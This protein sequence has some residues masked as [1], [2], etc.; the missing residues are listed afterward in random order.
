MDACRGAYPV[1]MMARLLAV[2]SSGY[3]EWRGRPL[4]LRAVAGRRLVEEMRTIHEER[5]GT[6]GSPR[7]RSELQARGHTE[8]RHRVARLMRAAHLR[9]SIKKR[10]RASSGRRAVGAV[11]RNVLNRD[12]IP[13]AP[14]Q[15][16]AGDITYVRTDEGWIYL[17]VVLDLYS[18]RVVGWSMQAR[19]GADLVLAAMTMALGQRQP[20]PGLLHHSDRGS[21]YTGDGFQRLLADH[22]I[23]C[24]MSGR[25]NCFDTACVESFFASLKR[26]RVYRRRYRS[27]A[28]ARADLFQYIE[29]FY[30]RQRRHSLL[31]NRSP[32][33][34]EAALGG[35]N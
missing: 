35:P 20:G 19:I 3:Y 6:Y 12:F 17:A 15:V 16:W 7:K 9:G 18:R 31:G 14:N 1:R 13:P 24:S 25:G 5:D 27:R 4:S 33:E 32:A 11:A 29:V 30:H 23:R 21:Q 8:G 22:G 26:E 34:Y 28:E 10:Y 2:S